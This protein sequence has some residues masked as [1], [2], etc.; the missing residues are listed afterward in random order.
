[1][2]LG[3]VI[4]LLCLYQREHSGSQELQLSFWNLWDGAFLLSILIN[5]AVKTKHMYCI[6]QMQCHRFR[7]RILTI[8]SSK[9]NKTTG[10]GGKKDKTQ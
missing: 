8:W 9:Q 6:F 4:L 5:G 10:A 7:P 1:M 2:C 3:K